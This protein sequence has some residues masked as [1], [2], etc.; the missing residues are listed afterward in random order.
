MRGMLLVRK[1]QKMNVTEGQLL[2]PKQEQDSDLRY[3]SAECCFGIRDGL[4]HFA[5]VRCPNIMY[6]SVDN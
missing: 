2:V 5:T 3:W 4:D 1:R 6:H